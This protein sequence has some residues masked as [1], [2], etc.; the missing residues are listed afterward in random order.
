MFKISNFFRTLS[1]EQIVQKKKSEVK[2]FR[3]IEF[4][5]NSFSILKITIVIILLKY[6]IYILE[7][8]CDGFVTDFC[9]KLK[10]FVNLSLSI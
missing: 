8:F 1:I 6:S 10:I 4:I 7:K 3:K 9:R 5:F 2:I